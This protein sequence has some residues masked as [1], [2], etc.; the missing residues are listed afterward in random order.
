MI[1]FQKKEGSQG[2]WETIIV[3][4]GFVITES[5]MSPRDMLGWALGSQRAIR[6]NDLSALMIDLALNG[7]PEETMQDNLAMVL[8]GGDVL[9]KT[10]G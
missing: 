9:G 10:Q 6:V 2:L 1:G 3:K 5:G 7:S 8:R 4:A